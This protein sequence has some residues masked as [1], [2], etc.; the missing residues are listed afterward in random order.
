[1]YKVAK[2]VSTIP[3]WDVLLLGAQRAKIISPFDL[4][5]GE[6]LRLNIVSMDGVSFK[7]S[8]S[9]QVACYLANRGLSLSRDCLQELNNTYGI[10]YASLDSDG[11]IIAEHNDLNLLHD[12]VFDAAKLALAMVFKLNKHQKRKISSEIN[13]QISKYFGG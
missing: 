1:M 5:D 13:I 9:F 7:L 11:A 3:G 12:A 2:A 4:G 10:T 6:H 8:D